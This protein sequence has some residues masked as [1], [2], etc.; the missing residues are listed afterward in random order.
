M[1]KVLIMEDEFFLADDCEKEA[2]RAGLEVA[3]PF[4]TLG[5]AKARIRDGLK[6]DAA[7][8]DINLVGEAV[9]PLLD[10]LIRDGLPIVIYTGYDR[11]H[12]PQRFQRLPLYL[13]PEN[14]SRAVAH[15][16][17]LL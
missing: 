15:L 6:V 1:P 8:I 10:E 17:R 5:D 4:A 7:L 13:K 2:R 11:S 14:C 3:G 12:L 9:Y 16:K